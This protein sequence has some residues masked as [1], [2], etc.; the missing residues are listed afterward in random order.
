MGTIGKWWENN[1]KRN[2]RKI[3]NKIFKGTIVKL[4]IKFLI[5]KL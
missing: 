1:M 4:E 2:D 5:N 3:G